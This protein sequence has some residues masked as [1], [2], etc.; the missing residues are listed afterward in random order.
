MGFAIAEAFAKAGARV[1]LISGPTS[2]SPSKAIEEYISIK[3]SDEMYKHCLTHFPT[4]D[5]AILSAAVADY[6]ADKQSPVKIKSNSDT[7]QLNLTKTV[8]IA[9]ELG[10]RKHEKQLLIGFALETNNEMH[11]AREKLI[12]KNFDLIVLNSLNEKGAGF[13]YDTN[14]VTIIDRDNN[15]HNFGLKSKDEVASDILKLVTEKIH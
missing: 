4:C 2:L 5:L 1:I 11:N 13:E 14:K 3:T 15:I 12:R 6:K 8:D 7:F 9:F 10:K